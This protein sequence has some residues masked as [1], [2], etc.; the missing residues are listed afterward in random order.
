MAGAKGKG[1][2][3]LHEKQG[4][5]CRGVG[6]GFMLRCAPEAAMRELVSDAALTGAALVRHLDDVRFACLRALRQLLRALDAERIVIGFISPDGTLLHEDL[7]WAQGLAPCGESERVMS[8]APFLQA[9]QRW[10]EGSLPAACIPIDPDSA[11]RHEMPCDH[12]LIVR[13]DSIEGPRGR[14]VI[15][16][17]LRHP[18][19]LS[20]AEAL[21]IS[22][23]ITAYYR[24][25]SRVSC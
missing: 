6:R 7:V 2:T 15:A 8:C 23:L 21:A 3:V 18:V 5:D 13:S 16:A 10:L 22:L 4:M 14:A 25:S 24:R 1:V 20:P 19:S 17:Q 11:A 12:L 9:L